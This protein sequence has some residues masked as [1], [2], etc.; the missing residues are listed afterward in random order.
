MLRDS[1][2]AMVP[3]E[4]RFI[5]PFAVVVLW[6]AFTG[7][8]LLEKKINAGVFSALGAAAFVTLVAFEIF[9]PAA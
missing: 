8:L 1:V 3:S 7:V 4:L 9:E 5:W 2:A 6:F